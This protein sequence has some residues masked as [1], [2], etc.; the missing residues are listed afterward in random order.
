VQ[1][2]EALARQPLLD[3]A[4]SRPQQQDADG[5]ELVP[6]DRFAHQQ[7]PATIEAHQEQKENRVEELQRGR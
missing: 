2:E 6:R 1:V 5:V 3:D 4:V 7:R